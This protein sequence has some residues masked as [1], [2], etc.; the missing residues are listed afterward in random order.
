MSRFCTFQYK[1][2]ICS[3][4]LGQFFQI[5]AHFSFISVISLTKKVSFVMSK[6]ENSR[7]SWLVI[8]FLINQPLSRRAPLDVR[9]PRLPDL[10]KISILILWSPYSWSKSHATTTWSLSTYLIY[11]SLLSSTPD[12]NHLPLHEISS[13]LINLHHCSKLISNWTPGLISRI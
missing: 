1:E 11:S 13:L 5:F 3:N 8:I 4:I 10:T 9:Y 12:F 7:F 2:L 6:E